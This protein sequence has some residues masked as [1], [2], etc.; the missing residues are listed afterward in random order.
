ML[1]AGAAGRGLLPGGGGAGLAEGGRDGAGA[2]PPR[3]AD[4]LEAENARLR[5]EL[6]GARER[7]ARLAAILES[8]SDYAILTTDPD[9][10]VTSWNAGAE[11]LLGWTEAEALGM[12]SRLTF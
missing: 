2:T 7:E 1:P 6:D 11:R 3:R 12:D 9:G 4:E 5:R 8:A 10:R